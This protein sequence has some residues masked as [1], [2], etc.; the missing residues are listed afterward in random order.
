LGWG[1][2][3]KLLNPVSLIEDHGGSNLHDYR[4]SA[5]LDRVVTQFHFFAIDQ[6][7]D[8]AALN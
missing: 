4:I 7:R 5:S 8:D 3:E 2:A 6:N 1:L